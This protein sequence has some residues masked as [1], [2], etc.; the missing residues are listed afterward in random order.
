MEIVWNEDEQIIQSALTD[1]T[2]SDDSITVFCR[3]NEIIQITAKVQNATALNTLLNV[4]FSMKDGEGNPTGLELI[5]IA[6]DNNCIT[7]DMKKE[8]VDHLDKCKEIIT[9]DNSKQLAEIASMISGMSGLL[10]NSLGEPPCIPNEIIRHELAAD[11]NKGGET[12]HE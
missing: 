12:A 2:T 10:G 3:E 9:G 11:T 1:N 5:S 7:E 4:L 6:T 8:I